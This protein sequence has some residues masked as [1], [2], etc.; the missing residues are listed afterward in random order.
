MTV[1][2]VLPRVSGS[3][4]S[5]TIAESLFFTF[6]SISK[7]KAQR[8][9]RLDKIA[10]HHAQPRLNWGCDPLARRSIAKTAFRSVTRRGWKT[11]APVLAY[12]E[13]GHPPS[14]CGNLLRQSCLTPPSPNFCFYHRRQ[15]TCSW[16]NYQSRSC[17]IGIV[18][19]MQS[20]F[21]I[22]KRFESISR[23]MP[24][25]PRLVLYAI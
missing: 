12:R 2:L 24:H 21:V 22:A 7:F 4:L 16:E 10:M 13:T 3:N 9:T 19:A 14:P 23:K 1:R 8:E 17:P 18:I 5:N 20:H 15:S 25:N 6:E 11:A